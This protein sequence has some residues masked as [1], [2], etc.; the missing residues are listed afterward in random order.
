MNQSKSELSR[1]DFHKQAGLMAIAPGA[2]LSESAADDTTDARVAS[3]Q[4]LVS[5][6]RARFGQHITEPEFKQVSQAVVRDFLRGELLKRIPLNNSDE[7]AFVFVPD[8]PQE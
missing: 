8:L 6:V 7:P 2:F 5:L 3:A 1:R 4:A